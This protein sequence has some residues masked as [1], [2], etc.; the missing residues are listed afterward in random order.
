MTDGNKPLEGKLALV[1]GAS[2]GIGAATAKS[3]AAQG[4]QVILVARDVKALETVEDEIHDAGGVS[5]IAPLDLTE[6]ESIAR[7]AQAISGRW[8]TLDIMVLSA[9]YLPTLTPVT[10]IE[11]KQFNQ[12]LNLN[13][14]A[15]QA[16]LAAFDP[17]LK[18]SQSASVIGLTSSVGADPRSYWSAYGSSK[19]AFDNILSSYAQEVE[20]LSNISV[21]IVDPGATRTS[22]RAKAYPGE[23]PEAVKDPGI[24]GNRIAGLIIDGFET[25]HRERVKG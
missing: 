15:T 18:R 17:M 2:K 10:Q 12:A 9:A 8:D 16:L 25:Q 20:K 7:L 23:D 21:A 1:T 22:M 13:V 4:A 24:V 6:P 3:L 19:A 11:P 5:T 14:L